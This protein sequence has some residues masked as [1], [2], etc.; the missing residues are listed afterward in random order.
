MVSGFRER[1]LRVKHQQWGAEDRNW[2]LLR[3]S[4]DWR[5][6]GVPVAV[7]LVLGAIMAFVLTEVVLATAGL[8]R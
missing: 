4:R 1:G 5:R 2:A 6:L 7:I 8:A 3:H